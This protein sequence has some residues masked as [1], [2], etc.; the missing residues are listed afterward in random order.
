MARGRTVGPADFNL[1]RSDGEVEDWNGAV[2]R[3]PSGACVHL[4]DGTDP[5]A[6][7]EPEAGADR[8][9]IAG[10]TEEL[11]APARLAGLAPEQLG[12]AIAD[13]DEEVRSPVVIEV[14]NCDTALL[15]RDP[16]AALGRRNGAE[17]TVTV[18]RQH[19]TDAGIEAGRLGFGGKEVLCEEDVLMAVA[20]EV[21]DTDSEDRRELGFTG[22]GERLESVATGEQHDRIAHHEREPD[23]ADVL[24]GEESVGIGFGEVSVGAES[25]RHPGKG[26]EDFVAGAPGH[27]A[28]G[29][30]VED[31][32]QKRDLA[33][34]GEVA[35]PE[36]ES[37][38]G[39]FARV[40][41][42][43]PDD[44]IQVAVG[45]EVAGPDPCPSTD[46]RGTAVPARCR[47][48]G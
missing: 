31:R 1:G 24:S 37:V 14:G 45:V 8:M 15:S 32:L 48:R 41:A 6:G 16:D 44:Q 29:G 23:W 2:L 35:V 20:V 42:P 38:G 25:F 19:E 11:K 27:A 47:A 34:A 10:G 3:Q 30:R 22:K 21:G 5:V 13:A 12:L 4:L 36:F 39:V 46:A 43:V 40:A 26:L 28:A 7:A 18:A 33:G 9:G 17:P